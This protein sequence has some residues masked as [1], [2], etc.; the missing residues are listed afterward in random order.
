MKSKTFL[1]CLWTFFSFFYCKYYNTTDNKYAI[2][3]KLDGPFTLKD[4]INDTGIIYKE[5]IYKLDSSEPDAYIFTIMNA[6][7]DTLFVIIDAFT[8][9]LL[10]ECRYYSPAPNNKVYLINGYGIVCNGPALV[11][12]IL[13]LQTKKY[14]S[15]LLLPDSGIV[16]LNLSVKSVL[17]DSLNK[18]D[19]NYID[20]IFI[21]IIH[22]FFIFDIREKKLYRRTDELNFHRNIRL[23]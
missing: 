16:E 3:L 18:M 9:L 13:P 5:G 17:I 11:D 20:K 21:K 1:F 6:G 22:P 4:I 19:S 12:T 15:G 23:N 10:Q 7:I 14:Y 8:G 2:D